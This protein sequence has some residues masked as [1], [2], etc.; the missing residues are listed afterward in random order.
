MVIVQY[1]FSQP[2]GGMRSLSIEIDEKGSDLLQARKLTRIKVRSRG[3]K[4]DTASSFP[5]YSSPYIFKSGAA[6][7]N[8]KDAKQGST[9]SCKASLSATEAGVDI[10]NHVGV[11]TR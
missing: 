8:P 6:E 5:F 2:K 9:T 3:F 1:Y 7:S 10:L 11:G 4:E